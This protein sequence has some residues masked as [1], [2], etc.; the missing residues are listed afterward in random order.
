MLNE[1]IN[2]VNSYLDVFSN[3][4]DRLSL[5]LEFLNNCSGDDV[6]DWNNVNGHVTVG[7]FIY[8]KN[9]DKFLVLYHKDLKMFLYPGGHID[10]DDKDLLGAVHRE[11]FEECGIDDLELF[12]L[13]SNGMPFDID[14]HL[15][16]DNPRVGMMR[17]YHY[18]FR[19]LYYVS[20]IS[21][22]KYDNDEL[23]SYK[24]ISSNELIND[25]NFG[26]TVKKVLEILS[27][28]AF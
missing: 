17:H 28:E 9:K 25:V 3:E 1:I 12:S 6:Y 13:C 7:A 10:S 8:C 4:V 19:Y 20:D 24:W 18:D 27:K 15:I 23:S 2:A 11:V 21:D 26:G 14:I 16:P 5:L 22:V